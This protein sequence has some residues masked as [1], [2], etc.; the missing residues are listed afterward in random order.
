MNPFQMLG[1]SDEASLDDIKKAFRNLSMQYH[2][3]KNGSPEAAD[4]FRA[5]RD[6]Y[7]LITTD[8][9]IKRYKSRRAGTINWDADL[10]N[11]FKDFFG[12]M[13]GQPNVKKTVYVTVAITLEEA[14]RGGKKSF[15]YRVGQTCS[16]CGGLG[17]TQFDAQG[18]I[19]VVCE[20]CAGSGATSQ[21]LQ[22]A[23]DIP[24]SVDNG[25]VLPAED[26]NVHVTVNIVPHNS[27][28]RRQF[29]IFSEVT[30]PLVKVFD[31]SSAVVNTL[32]GPVDVQIPKCIQH[33]QQLRIKNHGMWD[34]RKGAFADHI[35]KLKIQ[36]PKL[37]DEICTRIVEC[38]NGTEKE[39]AP[40]S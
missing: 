30:I 33:D 28:E 29:D 12:H 3:D 22:T 5:I 10:E 39:K 18:K 17:A 7:E 14:F 31:G 21:T 6:A 15:Y 1:L 35:I 34:F 13:N 4:K 27:F 24:Q 26:P 25:R 2:P 36:I 20:K 8:Q 23:V 11:Y 19:K 16:K 9:K 40:S 32:H 37:P 38:L